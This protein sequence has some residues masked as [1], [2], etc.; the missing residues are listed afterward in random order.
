MAINWIH[1]E[2]G[3]IRNPTNRYEPPAHPSNQPSQ[4]ITH[5]GS[6]QIAQIKSLA[7]Q[8]VQYNNIILALDNLADSA[9]TLEPYSTAI[10]KKATVS[11][12]SILSASVTDTSIPSTI[13]SIDINQLSTAQI[14]NSIAY[15]SASDTGLI[16]SGSL[17]IQIG[18]AAVSSFTIDSTTSLTSLANAIKSANSALYAS[19]INDGTGYRLQITSL[20]TGSANSITFT[21]SGTD[22]DLEANQVQA[23]QDAKVTINQNMTATSSS[24]LFSSAI[25]GI[26]FTL[27]TSSASTQ[28]LSVTADATDLAAYITTF[29]HCYNQLQAAIQSSSTQSSSTMG[30]SPTHNDSTLINLS[31]TLQNTVAIPSA[32][33]Q[34]T[35][36]TLMQIGIDSND[37]G[38]LTLDSNQ[39]STA[40]ATDPQ[41]VA[42]L[43]SNSIDGSVSGI[44]TQIDAISDD[45]GQADGIIAQLTTAKQTQINS[46]HKDVIDAQYTYEAYENTRKKEYVDLQVTLSELREQNQLIQSLHRR[47]RGIPLPPT[48]KVLPK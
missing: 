6:R 27:L 46:L 25:S 42:L 38:S 43:F 32:N 16:A 1:P 20:A 41:S 34:G 11:D 12:S 33:A 17:E 18:S 5:P 15:S 30:W 31:Q 2:F 36:T 39:L 8:I 19:V 26:S 29:V 48:P 40:I 21:E 23:A 47:H 7:A 13:Y 28:T 24:N 3:T 45:Y 22:L 9:T 44:A 35:Y 10:G 14:N 4:E 37:D